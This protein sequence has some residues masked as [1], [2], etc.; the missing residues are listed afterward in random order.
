[1][2]LMTRITYIWISLSAVFLLGCIA[3]V[4][5]DFMINRPKAA[6][7]QKILER[8]FAHINRLPQGRPFGYQATHGNEDAL[9]VE[10]Y[11]THMNFTEIRAYYDQE[12]SRNGWR[13]QREEKLEQWGRDYGGKDATYCKGPFQASLEYRY[14]IPRS[15]DWDYSLGV[16]WDGGSHFGKDAATACR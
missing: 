5:Y 15:V 12:L 13:F 10:F 8:E 16:A 14:F 3:F 9:V 1:M 11:K 7:V 6:A 4:A 2:K